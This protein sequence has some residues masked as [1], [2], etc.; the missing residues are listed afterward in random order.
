M[1]EYIIEFHI[2]IS[3]TIIVK[4]KTTPTRKEILAIIEKKYPNPIDI[5]DW[6]VDEK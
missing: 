6:S 2:T 5:T 3:D 4:Q 1:K